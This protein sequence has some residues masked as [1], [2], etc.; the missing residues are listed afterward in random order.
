[1]GNFAQYPTLILPLSIPFQY[2]T[3]ILLLSIPLLIR[4]WKI[5]E[6]VHQ[7]STVILLLS[8]PNSL[9]YDVE[10]T[11]IDSSFSIEF[12]V[13]NNSFACIIAIF[14]QKLTRIFAYSVIFILFDGSTFLWRILPNTQRLYYRCLYLTAFI[15]MSKQP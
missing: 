8:I 9:H 4:Y 15:M 10:T 11:V 5:L 2:S 14:I 3:V 13:L 7:Y 6:L 12:T 1:M